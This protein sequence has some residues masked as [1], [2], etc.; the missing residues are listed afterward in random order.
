VTNGNPSWSSNV[1]PTTGTLANST[2]L[3]VFLNGLQFPIGLEW[4][5]AVRGSSDELAVTGTTVTLQADFLSYSTASWQWR[6]DGVSIP[7]ATNTFTGSSSNGFRGLAELT[8]SSVTIA[9]AGNYSLLVRSDYENHTYL[10]TNV[11]LSVAV[12]SGGSVYFANAGAG[13]NAPVV[14]RNGMPLSGTNWFLEL[15]SGPDPS[16][17]LPVREP[18]RPSFNNGYFNA[19]VI[20]VPNIAPGDFGVGQIRVWNATLAVSFAEAKAVGAE[21]YESALLPIYTGRVGDP[22]G[23][24]WPSCPLVPPPPALRATG[25]N[26][27]GNLVLG[28][29]GCPGAFHVEVSTNLSDW[30]LFT[31]V[32][33]SEMVS[34]FQ[35]PFAS[36]EGSRF[37]RAAW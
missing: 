11:S 6:K 14:D 4:V 20:I 13:V 21:W 35:V 37:Y 26:S 5:F 19:G 25:V 23:Q 3:P 28:R 17:L 30:Q 31:T 34:E 32:T 10:S 12:Q 29:V 33:N 15:L 16:R 36:G 22:P 27:N 7:G 2:N 18:V 1:F 24:L 8:L 9:D